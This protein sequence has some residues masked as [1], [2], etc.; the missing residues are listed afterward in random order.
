MGDYFGGKG[1][2]GGAILEGDLFVKH[3]L[4]GI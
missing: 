1:N 4:E 3:N 2:E